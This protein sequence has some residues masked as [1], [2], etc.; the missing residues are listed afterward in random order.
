[1]NMVVRDVEER[2]VSRE[3]RFDR[4]KPVIRHKLGLDKDA[5]LG[6]F[7]NQDET[8]ELVLNINVDPRKP[9][10]SLRGMVALPHGSGKKRRVAVFTSSGDCASAARDAGALHA[11]GEELVDEILSGTVSPDSFDV[12]LASPDMMSVLGSRAARIL[13]PRGKMP[14]AKV[15]TVFPT[16]QMTDAVLGQV[17]AASIQ[18]RTEKEGIIQVGIGK[19]SQGAEALLDNI[20]AFMGEIQDSKP[21][22][23]GRGK[24][25]GGGK[26]GSQGK[27]A[28]SKAKYYLA[29]HITSTQG[30]S[31]K[32]DIRTVD[33]TSSF[34]MSNLI[35]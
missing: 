23:Y 12:A 18:Y 31:V 17:R 7:R 2:K 20:R 8:I 16:D 28:P 19:G 24:K 22:M 9:G 25:S 33:P 29:A 4:N 1:M 27:K 21:D 34:F 35:Q 26:G 30:K 3:E 14:S 5:D 6:P 10:Q 32:L 11:G 15:G 13:G